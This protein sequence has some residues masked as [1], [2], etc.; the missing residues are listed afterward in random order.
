[1]WLFTQYGFY[2]IVAQPN[3]DDIFIVRSRVRNDLEN[4][5]TL[6]QLE[7]EIG[8]QQNA[9]L[10]YSLRLSTDEWGRAL[11][12]LGATVDYPDFQER[13]EQLPDQSGKRESYSQ[14]SDSVS[15]LSEPSAE[16]AAH[17]D[18]EK[19]PSSPLDEDSDIES[20][21]QEVVERGQNGDHEGALELLEQLIGRAPQIPVG[22]WMKGVHLAALNRQEEAVWAFTAGLELDADDPHALW[23]MALACTRTGRHE[24]AML[25]LKHALKMDEEFTDALLLLGHVFAREN[26]IETPLDLDE[27][28]SEYEPGTEPPQDAVT[29][30]LLMLAQLALEN[31][32]MARDYLDTLRDVDSELAEQLGPWL[33]DEEEAVPPDDWEEQNDD[34][35]AALERAARWDARGD[36]PPEATEMVYRAF[37]DSWLMV[38]L[39]DA[40]RENEEGNASLSLRSGALDGIGGHTGLVAFTDSEA[41]RAF[42]GEA[43]EHNV[44]LS[45]TDLCQALAQMAS[46]WTDSGHPPAALVINPGGPH[47]YALGLPNLVFLA[48]GGVPLDLEHAVIGEGTQVEIRVPEDEGER[49]SE[50]LLTALS[51]A[52]A[53]TAARTGAREVWWFLLR[54]GDGDAHLGLGVFPGD[55]ETVDAVGRAVN[56][57]WWHHAPSLAVYDVLGMEDDMEIRIRHSGELLWQSAG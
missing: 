43:P 8:E 24:A 34:L 51:E 47:P 29:Y 6:A 16:E 56:E 2:S 53:D 22:Y 39:N 36:V 12:S 38:P 33:E 26:N 35:R 4:L 57:A 10:P 3:E 52:I 17:E 11:A 44:V 45:G 5:R 40:P 46:H 41:E 7:G 49:P 21:Y 1:M 31:E 15:S 9:D 42:F 32:D 13:I 28:L 25:S 48:T 27:W 14:V 55:R 20:L 18:N 50:P 23:N 37:L 30:Q 19:R 54:F